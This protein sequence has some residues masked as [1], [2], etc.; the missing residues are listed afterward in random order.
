MNEHHRGFEMAKKKW[1]S[2]QVTVAEAI[3]IE[4]FI[5]LMDPVNEFLDGTPQIDRM[6]DEA[7][8]RLLNGM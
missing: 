6:G 4:R 3:V 1:K 5:E 2:E 8:L 7:H